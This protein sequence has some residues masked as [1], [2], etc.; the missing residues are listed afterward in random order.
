M[1][2]HTSVWRLIHKIWDQTANGYKYL[3]ISDSYN[4]IMINQVFLKRVCKASDL[5]FWDFLIS[6]FNTFNPFCILS[7]QSFKL[8]FKKIFHFP[9]E[10]TMLINLQSHRLM[11]DD[12]H[13][14]SSYQLTGYDYRSWRLIVFS[15]MHPW[16]QLT[17]FFA[18]TLTAPL[19]FVCSNLI[20][21]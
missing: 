4:K 7:G 8:L 16:C 9:E 3:Y 1:W 14:F 21:F 15:V 18:L 5:W 2:N 17:L 6:V 20:R 19:V 12:E 10:K 11:L 13:S